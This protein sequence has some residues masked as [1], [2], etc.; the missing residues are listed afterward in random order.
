MSGIGGPSGGNGIVT[1]S[2]LPDGSAVEEPARHHPLGAAGLDVVLPAKATANISTGIWSIPCA[3]DW[4]ACALSAERLTS[5]N[6]LT[7]Q[8]QC[9]SLSRLPSGLP[10]SIG[11]LGSH[12]PTSSPAAARLVGADHRVT[13]HRAL[14]VARRA[15]D[16]GR[17][18][19]TAWT[20]T[21]SGWP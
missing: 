8:A 20:L 11:A 21:W 18:F 14:E 16:L 7:S 2:R 1:A 10:S 13:V 17:R 15:G 4:L 9:S 6:S 12:S 19:V 5:R 3:S